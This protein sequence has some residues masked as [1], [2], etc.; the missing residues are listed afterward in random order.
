MNHS[1]M[2]INANHILQMLM[3]IIQNQIQIIHVFQVLLQIAAY[4]SYYDVN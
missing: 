4:Q 1:L 2:T 3:Q